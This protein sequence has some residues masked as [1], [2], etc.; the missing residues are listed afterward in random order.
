MSRKIKTSLHGR[1]V[2][3]D[4]SNNVV[5]RAFHSGSSGKGIIAYSPFVVA[6]FDDFIDGAIADRAFVATEGTDSVT[7][8]L[9]L[10]AGGIGG[11][12][13]FT[14]GDTGTGYAADAEQV[15]GSRLVWQ[16]VNGSLVFETR[17]KLSA[18]TTCYVFIGFTDTVAAAL[19]QPIFSAGGTTFTT[20]A[21]DAVGF[22]FDTGMTVDNWWCTGVA[23]NVDSVMVDS[24]K[25]PVA[26]KYQTFRIEV[27][28][29]GNAI[30]YIDDV[31]VGRVA[32]AV[33]PTIDLT[34]VATVSKLSVAASMTMDMDYWSSSMDR[35]L[36]GAAA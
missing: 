5:A 19:E 10:L 1:L 11:V 21:T 7:S 25:A 35:G 34:R 31:T 2:G 29:L 28:N 17:L 8:D 12:L 33:T 13:R 20:N 9:T 27:D 30:F 6:A 3:L 26:D 14:T 15:T 22:M 18:I 24:G 16:A 4:H 23:N 32:L 36:D